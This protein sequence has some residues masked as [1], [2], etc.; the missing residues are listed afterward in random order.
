MKPMQ[1]FLVFYYI[2]EQGYMKYKWEDIAWFLGASSP[3]FWGD[4]W[5][6]DK[7]IYNDWLEFANP[8]TA[9]KD[10]II[11]KTYDFLKY[12]EQTFGDD[13]QKTKQW[14][15]EEAD[16]KT[17]QT[18]MDYAIKMYEIYHYEC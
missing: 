2:L 7:A 5:P 17:V 16:M 13:Y 10:N 9:T 15:I 8:K 18:A 14:L 1:S 3:E 12:Y 4:G 6:M 11:R